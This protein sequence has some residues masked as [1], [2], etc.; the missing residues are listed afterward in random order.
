MFSLHPRLDADTQLIRDWPLCR[1]LLMKDANYPWLI[2]VPRRAEISEITDL[3][4]EVRATLMEEVA[5]ASSALRE[6]LNPDRVNVAAL[7]NMVPQLHV[8]VI[9]RFATDPAWPK[10][11]WGAV[12]AA[13]YEPEGLVGR[14]TELRGALG[15]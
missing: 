8:H 15:D 11:V 12:P 5:R 1:V 4:P 3:A 6:L 13:A 7:G 10:P 9:A 2:L 14:I